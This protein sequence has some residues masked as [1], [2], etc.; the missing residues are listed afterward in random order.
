MTWGLFIA[1]YLFCAG[2]GAGA[3]LSAITAESYSKEGFRPFVRAGYIISG[4]LIALGM[5][6]LIL[7][8]GMGLRE[9]WRLIGLVNNLGSMMTWG[10]II[11]SLFMPIAFV[12][13]AM[14]IKFNWPIPFVNDILWFLGRFRHLFLYAGTALAV[15]TAIY[16]GL[17][18][19]VVRGVPLWNSSILPA[20]FFISAM[21]SG[22]AATVIFAVLFPMEERR[23]M[24]QHFFYL[25]QVHSLMVVIEM[26]FVF[27]WLFIT[28]SISSSGAASVAALLTGNLAPFFWF[29]VVFLGIVDP[30]TIYVYEVVLGRPLVPYAMIVSD[31]SVLVGGFSL[32]YLV[33]AAAVAPVLW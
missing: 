16:T 26:I 7:D 3:F 27:S 8:L 22:L 4:P 11:L 21:S 1:I 10:T 12:L 25:N 31:A 2:A 32:R 17:L 24:A 20:L 15:C 30:L 14:E 33:L 29:G 9:P 28:A 19:G 6:W 23:L 13:G 5:P 18:I